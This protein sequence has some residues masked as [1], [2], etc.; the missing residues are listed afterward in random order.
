MSEVLR[1]VYDASALSLEVEVD[2]IEERVDERGVR[3][4]VTLVGVP[5]PKTHMT[6]AQLSEEDPALALELG[7]CIARLESLARA[8]AARDIA[9]PARVLEEAARNGRLLKK[10]EAAALEL[11]AMEKRHAQLSAEIAEKEATAAKAS[12]NDTSK[13]E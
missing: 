11:E 8:K 10:V 2:A 5:H 4:I 9:D 1:M 13:K 12:E 3:R 7:T 6:M